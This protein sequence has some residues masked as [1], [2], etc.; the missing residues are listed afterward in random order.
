MSIYPATLLCDFYKV[1]HKAQYPE[2]TEYV[3]STWTPRMSRIKGVD[4]VV[5][6]GIQSFISKYL[7]DYFNENFFG[8]PKEIVI[9]E[10]ENYIKYALG[11]EKPDSSHIEEL[12]DLGYL[13]IKIKAIE[14]GKVVPIRT[15]MMTI[16]NTHPKFFWV[17]N[18]LETL[19]ST[20]IWLPMTSATIALEYRKMLERYAEK[21][22]ADASQITF[23]AHDFSMRGMSNLDA[24]AASG[25]GHLLS[26][27]GTDTIPAIAYLEEYY[28]ADIKKE[29]VG[30]SIPATEHSVMCA[31]SDPDVRDEYES[32]RR[33]IND[34]YPKGFVSIVSD[35][36]DFWK[37]I[38]DVIPR[39]KDDIMKRDGKVVIRP[40]S[41]D[42]V[43]IL[44]GGN[45]P[46][47]K[48]GKW[49]ANLEDA[50]EMFYEILM[51]NVREETPHGE[52]G[53][54]EVEGV[55][56][57]KGKYYK[58]KIDIE[59]N[60]YD[61]QYY[62][63][64]GHRESKFEETGVHI[65]DI[66]LIEALWNIFGGT[67]N[68]K[69]YK[70]LDEHIGAIYGDSITLDRAN[71][72]L[73]RLE[74][75]GFASTNVVLGIG[76]FTYQYNT[77]DTFGFAM[78]ATHAVINGKEKELFKD[79]K[80]DNGVKKSQRGRVVVVENNGHLTFD[81]G[82]TIKGEESLVEE[83]ELKTVFL[84][85]FMTRFIPLMKVRENISDAI[86]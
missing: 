21:T 53:D 47:I 18:Y 33:L 48:D 34:V 30:A 54:T 40:D 65:S 37:V 55:F 23:Q 14:E 58:L 25:A 41:G 78:K 32:F 12:W 59:W 56:K 80:T 10:Y 2:G 15:P 35:T 67:I 84:N 17:T 22:G 57:Y 20:E 85:G 62:F 28:G 75:K 29:L 50:K 42:P 82:Y 5:S 61:K 7:V 44:C 8:I 24:A 79:P 64:D 68:E 72:I 9:G 52:H 31:N 38:S 74:Q 73:E 1:S 63:I 83:N 26:F 4:S 81:D 76:S 69:G 86:L 3:Y 19:L 13:P 60:R 43:D 11:E 66:G 6:F 36:Y 70:V 45:I 49:V 51:D 77:R 46:E 27:T 71:R 39:L 16:E